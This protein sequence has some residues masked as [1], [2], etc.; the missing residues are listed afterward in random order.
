MLPAWTQP[1]AKATLLG[2]REETT[3]MKLITPKIRPEVGASDLSLGELFQL[4]R[5]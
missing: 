4:N 2:W 5:Q 3:H 1:A